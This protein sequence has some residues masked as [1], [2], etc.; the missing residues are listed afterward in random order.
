M[1]GGARTGPKRSGRLDHDVDSELLPRQREGIGLRQRAH[2]YAV[3]DDPSRVNC[4]LARERPVH[5]VVLEQMRER[6]GIDEIVDGDDLDVC[7]LFVGGAEHAPADAAEAINRYS[8]W[9]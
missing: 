8:Y 5:R 6:G 9:H 3:D 7:I 1:L 2:L 4:D